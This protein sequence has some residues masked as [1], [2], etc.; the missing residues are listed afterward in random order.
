MKKDAKQLFTPAQEAGIRRMV[1]EGWPG[2]IGGKLFVS[3]LDARD[4]RIRLEIARAERW[5]LAG[6]GFPDSQGQKRRCSTRPD[7]G[8]STNI[9][10]R[11][12]CVPPCWG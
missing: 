11:P 7:V 1:S 8:A 6:D 3:I 4:E 5:N 12:H 10:R 2:S 9:P